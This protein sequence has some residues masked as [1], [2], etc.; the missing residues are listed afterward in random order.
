MKLWTWIHKRGHIANHMMHMCIGTLSCCDWCTILDPVRSLTS[1]TK[2]KRGLPCLLIPRRQK[3]GISGMKSR[4][5]NVQSIEQVQA[6]G[7]QRNP[8]PISPAN[9]QGG[10]RR[11]RAPSPR[12]IHRGARGARSGARNELPSCSPHGPKIPKSKECIKRIVHWQPL[13]LRVSPV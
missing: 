13:S 2:H 11:S 10:P 6:D 8:P 1:P 7:C 4:C 12:G 9:S 3:P 5:E